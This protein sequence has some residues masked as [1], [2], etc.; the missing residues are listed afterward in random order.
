MTFLNSRTLPGHGQRLAKSSASSA[1]LGSTAMPYRLAICLMKC[2]ASGSMSS[3]L[4]LRGA[5]G[6][7]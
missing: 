5:T 2:E 4:S 1:S 7:G 3:G 6:I